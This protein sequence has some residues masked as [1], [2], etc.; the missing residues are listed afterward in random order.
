MS[1]SGASLLCSWDNTIYGT[2]CTQ[3]G[4]HHPLSGRTYSCSQPSDTKKLC[5][6]SGLRR[7]LKCV[8]GI[9]WTYQEWVL[10]LHPTLLAICHSHHGGRVVENY[11]RE[12]ELC[13][14]IAGTPYDINVGISPKLK[15]LLRKAQH[16]KFS[17]KHHLQREQ[18]SYFLPPAFSQPFQTIFLPLIS[19]SF[20]PKRS[21]NLIFKDPLQLFH[22][23]FWHRAWPQAQVLTKSLCQ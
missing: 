14:R 2:T 23:S 6:H 8:P 20:F 19:S 5:L 1:F 15:T 21:W 13:N 3:T 9:F 16:S 12:F 17:I 22:Y 10:I 18:T 7:I 4:D 11:C